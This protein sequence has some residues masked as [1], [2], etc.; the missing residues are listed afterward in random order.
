MI[1][2]RYRALKV[3]IR[4]D[5]LYSFQQIDPRIGFHSLSP[6]CYRITY[7]KGVRRPRVNEG[8]DWIGRASFLATK[9]R[10]SAICAIA[11]TIEPRWF[12]FSLF[13]DRIVSSVVS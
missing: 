1:I 3:K 9:R 11:D 7:A 8:G 2:K 12:D 13:S 5:Q 4:Q 6:A 10:M